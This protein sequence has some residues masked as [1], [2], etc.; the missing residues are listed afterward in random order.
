MT[1]GP[2]TEQGTNEA[3]PNGKVKWWHHL[4]D[5]LPESFSMT[6]ILDEQCV[7]HQKGLWVR[8]IEQRQLRNK[9]HHHKTRDNEPRGRVVLL[10]FLT[11]LLSSRA[12]FPIKSLALSAHVSTQTIHFWVLEKSPLLGPGR[13]PPSCKSTHARTCRLKLNRTT[14]WKNKRFK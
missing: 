1:G 13:D 14:A 10:G 3:P 2:G 4:S 11:L 5:H 6:S 8:M 9:S 12:P 7:H